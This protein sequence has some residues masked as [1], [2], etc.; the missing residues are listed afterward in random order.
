MNPNIVY[1][2]PIKYV[3]LFCNFDIEQAINITH[4]NIVNGI[5]KVYEDNV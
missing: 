3:L 5:G 1:N 4:P 2:N